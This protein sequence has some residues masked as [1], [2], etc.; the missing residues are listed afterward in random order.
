[1]LKLKAYFIFLVL[2]GLSSCGCMH[3]KRGPAVNTKEAAMKEHLIK[4]NRILSGME[5]E[6]IMVFAQRKAWRT[7][8]TGTGLHI[9]RFKGSPNAPVPKTGD[10]IQMHYRS[11]L[12]S[13]DT[14]E[15]NFNSAPF[16]FALG[17]SRVPMGVQEACYY[18]APGDSAALI[19]PSHLGYGLTGDYDLGIPPK[20]SMVYYL[21]LISIKK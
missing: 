21:K 10:I 20:A 19:L 16:E 3:N 4:A 9:L 14:I 1:M 11:M 12:L 17:K 6:D 15:D 18:L 8:I 2:F 7:K 13:G 5:A